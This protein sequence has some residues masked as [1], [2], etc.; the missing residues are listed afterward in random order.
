MKKLL[1]FLT[2][3]NLNR[4]FVINKKYFKLGNDIINM[5]YNKI[6]DDYNPTFPD[7]ER[8]TSQKDLSYK[9]NKFQHVII[10]LW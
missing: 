2:L 4:L 8:N 5:N 7:I 3:I 6:I 10:K 9:Y 1:I